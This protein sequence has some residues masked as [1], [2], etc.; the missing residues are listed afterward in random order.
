M[1]ALNYIVITLSSNANTASLNILQQTEKRQ[2]CDTRARSCES[3][4]WTWTRYTDD[5]PRGSEADWTERAGEI[6]LRLFNEA[7]DLGFSA[8]VFKELGLWG[9]VSTLHNNPSRIPFIAA[10]RNMYNT[11]GRL[12]IFHDAKWLCHSISEKSLACLFK[13]R[14]SEIKNRNEQ[15]TAL[16]IKIMTCAPRLYRYVHFPVCVFIYLSLPLLPLPSNARSWSFFMAVS[17][18]AR[19]TRYSLSSP[20][21]HNCSHINP[22]GRPK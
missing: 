15:A 12:I 19:N 2:H 1:F 18:A 8:L 10:L 16:W 17:M 14:P 7:D 13:F 3:A 22:W 11:W 6:R 4:S 5:T 20:R 21:R 9:T